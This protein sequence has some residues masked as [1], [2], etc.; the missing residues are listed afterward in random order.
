MNFN[1]SFFDIILIFEKSWRFFQNCYQYAGLTNNT[2][3]KI[4][5]DNE[6]DNNN[7]PVVKCLEEN[8]LN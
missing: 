3:G 8:F 4:L 2:K 6:D 5:Q 7:M 1:V